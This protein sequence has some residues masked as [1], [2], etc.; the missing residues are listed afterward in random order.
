MRGTMPTVS[1]YIRK[2][3]YI[4]WLELEKPGEFI[5]NA[6]NPREPNPRPM[7]QKDVDEFGKELAKRTLGAMQN[8]PIKTPREKTVYPFDEVNAIANLN[9]DAVRLQ[10]KMPVIKS[11]KDAQK[12]TGWAGSNFKKGKK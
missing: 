6:L 10:D 7:T 11:P 9:H 3:D 1:V 5:H 4:K 8:K 2:E 12:A